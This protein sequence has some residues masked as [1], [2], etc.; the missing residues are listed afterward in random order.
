MRKTE[1]T[2]EERAERL[3]AFAAQLLAK[4]DDPSMR[5]KIATLM[6]GRSVNH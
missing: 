4:T 5:E 6:E 1:E 3:K 2:P